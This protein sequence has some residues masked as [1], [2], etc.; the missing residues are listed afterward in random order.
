MIK[1]TEDA[2][3]IRRPELGW[4]ALVCVVVALLVAPGAPA[5][6]QDGET[7]KA[8]QKSALVI[9]LIV[10]ARD[11]GFVVH[12]SFPIVKLR[13]DVIATAGRSLAT[14]SSACRNRCPFAR[15]E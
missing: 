14:M 8:E 4:P 15:A 12:P 10:E 7:E 1:C 13:D 9:E 2:I 5:W 11:T 3:F 6:P